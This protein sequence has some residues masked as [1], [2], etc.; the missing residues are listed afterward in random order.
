MSDVL[1][2]Y[3][4][5]LRNFEER[6]DDIALTDGDASQT[7]RSL[8]ELTKRM[9]RELR[10][11]GIQPGDVIGVRLPP[12]LTCL[13]SWA[14]FHEAAVLIPFN[15]EMVEDERLD[16]RLVISNRAVAD[17]PAE[18]NLVVSN[19]W[20]AKIHMNSTIIEPRKYPH[21]DSLMRLGLTSGSTGRPKVMPFSW[22]MV[23]Q[24]SEFT[25][26]A[27][28]FTESQMMLM[29]T[30]SEGGFRLFFGSAM[31]GQTYLVPNT[32]RQNV[33][34]LRDHKI[35]LIRASTAQLAGLVRELE[36]SSLTLPDLELI[37]PTGGETSRVLISRLR[38]LVSVRIGNSYASAEA[39]QIAI[40]F[41]DSDDPRDVGEV[42]PGA[43]VEIVDETTDQPVPNGEVGL[44]RVKRSLMLTSYL[45]PVDADAR[46]FHDGW[47]YPGDYGVLEG[48]RLS[49]RGRASENINSGGVKTDPVLV[50]EAYAEFDGFEDY[51]VFGLP[52]ND[53]IPRIALAYV[54]DREFATPFLRDH[55]LA[56]LRERTPVV[57]FRV[58]AIPRG[59]GVQ[60]VQRA[61]L[62]ERF[63]GRLKTSAVPI[64]TDAGVPAAAAPFTQ[65]FDFVKR[66]FE[67][68]PDAPAVIDINR[69]ATWKDVYLGAKQLA[70][71]LRD[72]GVAPGDI[73]AINLPAALQFLFT[74]AVFHEAAVVTN[75]VPEIVKD[76]SIDVKWVVTDRKLTGFSESQQIVVDNEFPQKVRNNPVDSV[77]RLYA[78]GS[79]LLRIALTSGTTGPPK[80]IPFSVSQTETRS[81]D[82]ESR[83]MS[84]TQTMCLMNPGLGMGW[85]PW[86]ASVVTQR[87]Y[88]VPGTPQENLELLRRQRVDAVMA[89]P[90]QLAD[91]VTL[92]RQ[93]KSSL[94]DIRVVQSGGSQ[95]TQELYNAI[96]ELTGATIMNAYGSTEVGPTTLRTDSANNP[97]YMGELLPGAVVEIVDPATHTPLPDNTPGLIRVRRHTMV[98]GYYRDDEATARAWRDGWF[99]SG[100]IGHLIGHRLYIAG[101]SEDVIDI[102]GTLVHPTAIDSF[103]STL[104]ALRDHATFSVID[105][106]GIERVALAYVSDD[107]VDETELRNAALPVL[108]LGTPSAFWRVNVIPRNAMGKPQ[109]RALKALYAEARGPATFKIA[110]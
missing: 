71:L 52:D 63:A 21:A 69:T 82:H 65:P 55:A 31:V 28:F 7:W 11:R 110:E 81:L 61:R 93:S 19:E 102:G 77:P 18:K 54:A 105:T 34:L 33:A 85:W 15:P 94:P 79:S 41:D 35:K 80:A 104:P 24:R 16:L 38:K 99:Y 49:L 2:P 12:M 5:L 22:T 25:F 106:L 47:F 10:D 45:H 89:S 88:I 64:P 1:Q 76:N 78:S 100:D 91:I 75:L 103:F 66:A 30:R 27:R 101:R 97:T 39:G 37:M 96:S 20:F 58:D 6:P 8:Y 4:Y 70:V 56:S 13:V 51:A 59:D 86:Y 43:T 32:D 48:N 68:A 40:R 26:S 73:V 17:W 42:A 3:D 87:P 36:R 46:I 72:R 83:T 98:D 9:A 108:R 109:R 84:D 74:L 50:E 60:K 53:G 14:I 44:V 62:T 23:A 29:G 107:A 92:L 67:R 90:A 95:L 57:F